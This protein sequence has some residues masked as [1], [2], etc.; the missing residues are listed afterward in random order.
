[1]RWLLF[2]AF[3]I[4]RLWGKI[5]CNIFIIR[6]IAKWK[7]PFNSCFRYESNGL[8]RFNVRLIL[9]ILAIS[10]ND[11]IVEFYVCT[12]HSLTN[13][14]LTCDMFSCHIF[15]NEFNLTIIFVNLL[16]FKILENYFLLKDY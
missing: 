5:A 16:I 15:L 7:T 11:F 13:V 12:V 3:G 10:D 8:N 4:N 1:M 6:A 14:T 9:K 2:A